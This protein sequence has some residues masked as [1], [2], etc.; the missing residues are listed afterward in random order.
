MFAS[1]IGRLQSRFNIRSRHWPNICAGNVATMRAAGSATGC[2]IDHGFFTLAKAVATRV[3]K[4]RY[5][6]RWPDP[7]PKGFGLPE[8]PFA[9]IENQGSQM[10]MGP[11]LSIDLLP[12]AQAIKDQR[13][14]YE[15]GRW[16]VADV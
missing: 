1:A 7:S 3:I 11:D 10:V 14:R 13:F 15:E 9:L 12:W 6:G 16:I 8:L 5:G 2:C 4:E